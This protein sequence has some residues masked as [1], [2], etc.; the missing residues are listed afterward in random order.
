MGEAYNLLSHLSFVFICITIM[1]IHILHLLFFLL[2]RKLYKSPALGSYLYKYFS[3]FL[4]LYHYIV[5][6]AIFF[7]LL[8]IIQIFCLPV[9]Q[10]M[11]TEYPLK[12]STLKTLLHFLW[13]TLRPLFHPYPGF[14]F[15][16]C[17]LTF[18]KRL[19]V[20]NILWNK[21]YQLEFGS[22]YRIFS[23]IQNSVSP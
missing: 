13:I 2:D 5:E 22:I 17:L 12:G 8:V 21:L 4:K 23:V 16:G 1:Y 6:L 20:W 14:L 3:Q 15:S 11:A 9:N 10:V 18:Y 19:N 7:K